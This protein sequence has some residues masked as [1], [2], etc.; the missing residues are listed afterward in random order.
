MNKDEINSISYLY[1][2]SP[3]SDLL[4]LSK[5]DGIIQFYSNDSW[6]ESLSIRVLNVEDKKIIQY[7]MFERDPLTKCKVN[8]FKEFELTESQ[9]T[10]LS[11]KMANLMCN[12][13]NLETSTSIDGN[14]F[15]L[16]FKSENKLQAYNWQSFSNDSNSPDLGIVKDKISN[17]IGD[18]MELCLI[19]NGT[20]KII[21]EQSPKYLDSF[22]VTAYI[23]D[24]YNLKTTQV[25]LDNHEIKQKDIGL[26][27]M[28]IH[29]NDT[30]NIKNR[31]HFKVELL[32]GKIIE[33]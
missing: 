11:I 10:S 31:I 23:R 13:V 22:E 12:P 5:L 21:V 18:L 20:K 28:Y 25:Y 33:L 32:N 6:T 24:Q 8:T 16:I 17:I 27:E 2:N 19:P 26:L 7:Y 15:S 29:K 30:L 4:P 1:N 3:Q 9:F 14:F